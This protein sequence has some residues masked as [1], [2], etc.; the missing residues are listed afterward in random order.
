M[1]QGT[2]KRGHHRR[3]PRLQA[4]P[5]PARSPSPPDGQTGPGDT[6]VQGPPP[7]RPFW[8]VTD[9]APG[10]LP[11]SPGQAPGGEQTMEVPWYQTVP[12]DPEPAYL[13]APEQPTRPLFGTPEGPAQVPAKVKKDVGA[14][15]SLFVMLPADLLV[16]IDPHCGAAFMQAAPQMVRALVPIICQSE[17]VTEFVLKSTGLILWGNFIMA[18]KPLVMAIVAHHV[19]K[20]VSTRRDSEDQPA[21]IRT[22][23]YS[24]YSAA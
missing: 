11:D 23:D 19:T 3:L 7:E 24:Q 14:V 8:D 12:P 5:E 15:L 22:T 17:A 2:W 21:E 20:T 9:A 6:P 4:V 18:S 1:V 10:G 16:M 13:Q